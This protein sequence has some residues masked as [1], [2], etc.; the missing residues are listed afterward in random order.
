L[1]QAF[2]INS[3]RTSSGILKEV[4]STKIPCDKDLVEQS[5][6]NRNRVFLIIL[7]LLNWGV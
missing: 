5:N 6:K 2:C 4:V 3:S 1:A 7:I